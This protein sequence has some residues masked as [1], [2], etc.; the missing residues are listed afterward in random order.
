MLNLAVEIKT[1][2]G[3]FCAMMDCGSGGERM[4]W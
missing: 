4:M 2:T 1:S 3:G